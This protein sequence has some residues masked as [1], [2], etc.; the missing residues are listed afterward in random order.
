MFII[1][2]NM[3]AMW[4]QSNDGSTVH[5]ISLQRDGWSWSTGGWDTAE[6][7]RKKGSKLSCRGDASWVGFVLATRQHSPVTGC[8]LAVSLSAPCACVCADVYRKNLWLAR[9]TGWRVVYPA[10]IVRTTVARFDEGKANRPNTLFVP[11]LIIF[12]LS[13]L[14]CLII[15]LC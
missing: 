7:E 1:F 5:S 14:P 15:S 2:I 11:C 9:E 4:D 12:F 13:S 8:Y 10:A 6:R 3:Q